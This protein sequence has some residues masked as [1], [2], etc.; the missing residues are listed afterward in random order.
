MG[1]RKDRPVRSGKRRGHSSS[2]R[3]LAILLCVAVMAALLGSA[4]LAAARDGSWGG[5][6]ASGALLLALLGVAVVS[7]RQSQ[8]S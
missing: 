7:W 8:G 1:K 6:A 3:Q 5:V 4:G 2:L